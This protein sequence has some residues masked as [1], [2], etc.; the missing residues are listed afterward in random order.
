V[1]G[2][3]ELRPG[4]WRWTAPHPDWRPSPPGS[5]GDWERDV[6]CV[7]YEADGAAVF[8]DPLLPPDPGRFWP[9]LDRRVR[10]SERVAVLTT[11]GWHR[12]S[13]DAIVD[14]YGATTSRARASLP[15]GVES[16]PIRRAGETMF[17]L[18]G[19]RA[20]VPGDRIL[21]GKRVGLRLCPDS[22]LDYLPS[23]ITRAELA[24]LL[25]P[26]LDLPIELVLVSHGNPVLG[27]GRAA[28]ERALRQAPSAA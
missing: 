1:Q 23:K 6:G 13:R 24:E 25:R 22:W 8:F 3:E 5:S 9:E 10:G 18:P 21:G 17:W 12:R 2:L 11:I 14:R 16:I 4:L 15:A 20:L 7:L 27:R 28:L 19:H 26:L